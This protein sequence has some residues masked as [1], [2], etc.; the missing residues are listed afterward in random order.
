M[1]TKRDTRAG[2]NATK[3]KTRKQRKKYEAPKPAKGNHRKKKENRKGLKQAAE[4]LLLKWSLL[5]NKTRH[6]GRPQRRNQN[7]NK[8]TAKKG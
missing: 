7:K 4:S 6:K 5:G 2:H 3:T 8:K 1:A